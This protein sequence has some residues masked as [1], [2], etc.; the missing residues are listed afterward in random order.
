MTRARVFQPG[1]FV[2][3]DLD[4]RVGHEQSGWR[5]AL[6]ISEA[7]YNARSGNL[8]LVCPITSQVKGYP[9][10]VPIPDGS[11]VHGVV[12]ADQIKSVDLKAR[13]AKYVG[14]APA[15]VLDTVRAYVALL[16][17]VK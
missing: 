16:I 7:S 17:G 11:E 3:V 10:E 5:P 2:T 15:E 14:A 12:L 8:V 6:T 4:P 13:R 9:F 1:D